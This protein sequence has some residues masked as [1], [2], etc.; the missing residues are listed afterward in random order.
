VE[1]VTASTIVDRTL[2]TRNGELNRALWSAAGYMVAPTVPEMIG[3]LAAFDY[4]G[5]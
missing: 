5:A 2:A 3:E 1:D 4:R